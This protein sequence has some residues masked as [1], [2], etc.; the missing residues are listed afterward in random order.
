M[1]DAFADLFH[2]VNNGETFLLLRS[3]GKLVVDMITAH[4]P[5]MLT[6]RN[7][8]NALTRRKTYME[9]VFGNA[10]N[11]MIVGKFPMCAYMTVFYPNV[12][13]LGSESVVGNGILHEHRRMGLGTVMHNPALVVHQILDGNHRGYQFTGSSEMIEFSSGEGKYHHFQFID[14]LVDDRGTGA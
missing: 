11:D 5:R 8:V 4:C 13:I 7:H 10:R 2:A 9:I 1:D 12:C 14:F 6:D 3:T